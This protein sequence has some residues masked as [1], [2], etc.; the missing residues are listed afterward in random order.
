MTYM[1][2]FIPT[3]ILIVSAIFSL[4]ELMV[5][6]AL[7]ISPE[8]MLDTVDHSAKGVEFLIYMWAV[9]QFALG[10]IFG[11]ATIKKSIPM[12]TIAYIFLL[13]MFAGDC[14]VGILQGELSL[15]ISALVMCVI[16]LVMLF[17]LNRRTISESN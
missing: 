11:F 10:I 1:P 17:F 13:I 16:A 9:R 14:F 8:S 6:V 12:L 3:W 15:I 2:N 5:S 4:I 7:F